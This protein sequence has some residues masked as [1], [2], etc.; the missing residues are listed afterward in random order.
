MGTIINRI[1]LFFESLP[2]RLRGKKY[3]IVFFIGIITL[4]LGAGI[5]K[6]TI[7]ESI[8]SYLREEDPVKI[9][10]DRFRSYF[11]SDEYVYVVYRARNNDI[12]SHDALAT[13]QKVHNELVHYRLTMAL[14]ETSPLDHIQDVTSLINVK[15]MEAADNT[16]FSRNFVGDILPEN[17]AQREALREKGLHHPDYPGVY[18]SRNSQY[19]GIVIRT[20]FN[21]E[22]AGRVS[23]IH[24]DSGFDD[25]TDEIFS[26]NDDVAP[27]DG[28]TVR[29]PPLKKSDIQEYPA[30]VHALNAIFEN[31]QYARVLEFYPVGNPVIMDF[32]ATAVMEDMSR[33]M[34]LVLV[35]IV[36]MLFL[37]FRSLSAVVWPVT[38][39][40]L[41]LVWTL[42]LIGWSGIA[43]SAMVMVI[44]FLCL[45]VGIADT[46]HILSGYLFFRNRH[47]S[48]TDAIN[49][50]MQKSALACLLTSITTGVGLIS[51]VLVPLKPISRFGVFASVAVMLAFLFTVVL[52]PLML[53][54]WNPAPKMGQAPKE[55]RV[56]RLIKKIEQVSI[57]RTHAVI[58]VF[59]VV[60]AVLFYG[61]LQLKVDSN[62]V[63]LI[64]ET[65]PLRQTYTIVDKHMGGTA[66]MEIM[67]AFNREEALKDP[68]VLYAIQ[69][70]QV[71]MEGHHG[72]TITQTMSLVNVVKDSYKALNDDDPEKYTIP[73]DSQVLKQVLFLFDSANPEDR[74]RLVSDD[75]ARG[76]IRVMSL[77][78]S[79]S[80]ALKMVNSIQA[81]MDDRFKPLQK[82]YPDM[83]ITLTG[84]MALMAIMLDYISWSQI[85]SFSLA[86][87]IISL[88]LLVVLGSWKAGVVSLIPNLFPILTAFGLM[89]FFKVPLDADTLIVAPIIIGLAVDDTI[90]FMTHFRL[91]MQRHGNAAT[92]A[93]Y[94]IR[95][96]GQA[97]TFTSL[98]LSAGFLVFLLSF[99]NGLSHFGLFS[100]VAILMALIADLFLLPALC[101]VIHVDFKR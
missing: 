2:H 25:E 14:H 97:I 3:W 98:I 91:E 36:G 54:L 89:G 47:L 34:A 8:E 68:D 56:L 1:N 10:Y 83:E 33:L 64:K 60:A 93:I 79:S 51:L 4:F 44:V 40:A 45:S 100:A 70:V 19:G 101:Q 24:M 73:V 18:L 78:V 52:L 13:L 75:Y 20:D 17:A 28:D 49:A 85:K 86:L 58:A 61:M 9:A 77:N 96:A 55:H 5:G 15:Y 65:L 21:A 81:F 71:Y 35:L 22:A 69:A 37:L 72:D 41:T 53:D 6:V 67:L 7:D 62:F 16:L 27:S 82:K 63:E 42:G 99:H 84:N 80:E 23:S 46:V 30:F 66:N 11:G 26:T 90:H 12:F 95:E 32:F 92:A 38:I 74:R 50:V 39:V 87:G 43:M 76:R 59:G 31:P 88:I 94:S 57:S 29:L 48:H